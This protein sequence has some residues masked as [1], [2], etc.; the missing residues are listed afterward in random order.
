MVDIFS[1]QKRSEIMSKIKSKN[2]K[3]EL[4]IRKLLYQKGYRYRLH[5]QNLPGKPDMVFGK[6]KKL[7]FINGCFW[8]GH[9]CGKNISPENNKLFWK[10]KI[11]KNKKRD[12]ENFNKLKAMGWKCLIVWQCEIK[13]KNLNLLLKKLISFLE[14]K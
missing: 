9:K 6:L 1:K 11:E 13:L 7:I 12:N 3:P 5:K 10:N 14:E 8:H 4:L 2:T